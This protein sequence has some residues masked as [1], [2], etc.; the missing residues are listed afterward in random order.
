MSTWTDDELERLD[1]ASELRIAGRK[2]N[3]TLR[4]LIVIWAVRVEDSIYVRSVNGPDAA[5]FRGAQ[6]RGEGHIESGGVSKDVTFTR[7][8]DKDDPIDTAYRAK[9]GSGSPVRAITSATA[10]STTLR[11]DPAPS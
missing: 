10:T 7:V 8:S 6:V 4:K 1:R 11:L 2:P 3:G 5:W 9:Y